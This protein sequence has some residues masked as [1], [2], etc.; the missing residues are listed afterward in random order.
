MQLK[1]KQL[2]ASH[3][4]THA[5]AQLYIITYVGYTCVFYFINEEVNS[6]CVTRASK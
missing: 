1:V 3:T 6:H 2:I 5:H 4:H